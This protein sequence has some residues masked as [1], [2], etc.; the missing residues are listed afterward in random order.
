MHP[1]S[2]M[3]QPSHPVPAPASLRRVD[4]FICGDPLGSHLRSLLP[5]LA[6]PPVSGV[7]RVLDPARTVTHVTGDAVVAVL[8][9]RV[10]T[11]N[12]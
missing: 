4:A 3:Y 9:S 8:I 7:D 6:A 1:W 2:K 11:P 5:L 10:D 12:L